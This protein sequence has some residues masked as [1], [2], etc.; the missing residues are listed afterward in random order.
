MKF[1]VPKQLEAFTQTEQLAVGNVYKC[2]GGGK[3]KYWIV[4][5]LSECGV[6]ML[7]INGAGEVT[8]TANY[9]RHVFELDGFNFKGRKL[10][11]RCDGIDALEF[12]ITW[13]EI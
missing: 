12:D 3:T 4:V 10:L 6:H 5:G 13:L 1:N 2:S 9:G 7:G 11:G 8:S